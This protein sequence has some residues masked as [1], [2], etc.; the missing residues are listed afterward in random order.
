MLTGIGLKFGAVVLGGLFVVAVAD[1]I[2]PMSE[3]PRQALL[4]TLLLW[5]LVSGVYRLVLGLMDRQARLA[6]A[7]QIDRAAEARDQPVVRGLS[8]LG[9]TSD[10][11]LAQSLIARAELQAKGLAERVEPAKAYPLRNLLKPG[12]WFALSCACWLALALMFPAQ[13][14]GMFAR[15]ALPWTAAPPF[16]LTQLDPTWTP[17][18][19]E[20]GQSVTISVSP[21]GREPEEVDVVLLDEEGNELERF[22]MHPDGQG[23]FTFTMNS[24]DK[25]ITFRLEANGRY[26]R[27]YTINPKPRPEQ[28]G[29]TD[30][31]NP[32][33]NPADA[34]DTGEQ[35]G[36]TTFDPNAVAQREL[37]ANPDWQKLQKQLNDL[38]DAMQKAQALAQQIDPN[39]PQAMRELEAEIAK[40][41][42]QANA[43]AGDLQKMQATL[44][45]DAAAKLAKLIDALGMNQSS[46]LGSCPGGGTGQPGQGNG[47]NGQPSPDQWRDQANQAL[48][49]DYWRIV[50][51][52][53]FSPTPTYSG[54]TSGS[55][56]GSTPDTSLPG[57]GGTTIEQGTGGDNGPLPDAVMQQV[58]PSYRAFI[59]AYFSQSDEPAPAR[60]DD[61]P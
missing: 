40:L 15:V 26:T 3:N 39:D 45:P 43:L 54:T 60:E 37:E 29:S 30:N 58:P 25:P 35:G 5:A 7:E 50:T 8:L 21:E 51:A 13:F 31:E 2:V 23:Q 52:L 34:A 59:R 41:I 57:A 12:R 33:S 16:S 61:K 20:K 14:F 46:G 4:V 32:S 18:S 19:P 47:G 27:P 6:A 22:A 36:S 48:S 9:L 44:A 28:P 49:D 42:A 11:P 10:D 53:G 55:S 38:L 24:I 17:D 56:A 1:A